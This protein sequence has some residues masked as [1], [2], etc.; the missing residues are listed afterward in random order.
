MQFQPASDQMHAYW[1][2]LSLISRCNLDKEMVNKLMIN[3]ADWES[4]G[5]VVSNSDDEA[6]EV[7]LHIRWF[8]N[9]YPAMHEDHPL[10]SSRFGEMPP[11]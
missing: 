6:T 1:I 2:N 3:T 5:L 8:V 4:C 9:L 11:T 10:L 7:Y